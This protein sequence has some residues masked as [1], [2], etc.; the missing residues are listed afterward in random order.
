MSLA[1]YAHENINERDELLRKARKTKKDA[2]WCNYKTKKNYCNNI[3]R[4]TKCR[5]E[6]NLLSE[7]E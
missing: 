3:V 1:Q 7:N 6:K 4:Q 2:D 5:Y